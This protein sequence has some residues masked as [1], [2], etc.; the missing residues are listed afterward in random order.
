M[1]WDKGLVWDSEK[2]GQRVLGAG[3]VARFGVD[4]AGQSLSLSE[5]H[6]RRI[7]LQACITCVCVLLRKPMAYRY[8]RSGELGVVLLSMIVTFVSCEALTL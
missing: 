3:N 4:G 1:R 2:E 6:G 8:I 7:V 5:K